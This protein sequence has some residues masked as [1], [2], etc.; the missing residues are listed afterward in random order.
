M[1]SVYW[2][3][4]A[5]GVN[6]DQSSYLPITFL[7]MQHHLHTKQFLPFVKRFPQVPVTN[8]HTLSVW[9]FRYFTLS[10][11]HLTCL[12]HIHTSVW[13]EVHVY[14]QYS[15]AIIVQRAVVSKFAYQRH[16]WMVWSMKRWQFSVSLAS[17]SIHSSLVLF[18]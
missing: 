12:A 14:Q 18:P 17:S 16:N 2:L 13:F 3:E 10:F 8:S 5:I 15:A 4:F 11:L 6:L 1:H 7:P 9:N